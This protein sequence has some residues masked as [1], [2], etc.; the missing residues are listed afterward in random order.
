MS[1][2]TK[3]YQCVSE[4]AVYTFTPASG[5]HIATASTCGSHS[6]VTQSNR[7]NDGPVAPFSFIEYCYLNCGP[8]IP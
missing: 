6:F 7:N 1:R 8:L 5:T 4:I 3:N 2:L